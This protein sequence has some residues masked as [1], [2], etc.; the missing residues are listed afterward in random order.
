MIRW[1]LA[2][3]GALLVFAACNPGTKVGVGTRPYR[4]YRPIRLGGRLLT[5]AAGLLWIWF[6][7]RLGR[8]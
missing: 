5:A 3:F 7:L 1:F 2:A 6:V 4:Q 8:R